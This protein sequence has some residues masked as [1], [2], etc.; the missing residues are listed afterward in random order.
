MELWLLYVFEQCS[1]LNDLL[2]GRRKHYA[3]RHSL[4]DLC[5]K[6]SCLTRS[7]VSWKAWIH[8]CS[9]PFASALTLK[10]FMWRR[11]IEKHKYYSAIVSLKL[12]LEWERPKLERFCILSSSIITVLYVCVYWLW[13]LE[14]G[15]LIKFVSW[16]SESVVC[17]VSN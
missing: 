2:V 13:L 1:A 4:C 14:F 8:S 17:C 10:Y 5:K 3:I 9:F 7:F 16:Y 11:T 12:M 6:K 15:Q